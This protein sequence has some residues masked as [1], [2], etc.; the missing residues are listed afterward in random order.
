MGYEKECD[1]SVNYNKTPS[2]LIYLFTQTCFS[3]CLSRKRSKSIDADM[4]VCTIS[5]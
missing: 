5:S 1:D 2:I 4:C 3:V